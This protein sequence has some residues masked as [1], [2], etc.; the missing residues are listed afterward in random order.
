[1]ADRQSPGQGR[2]SPGQGRQSPG[3]GR[4]WWSHDSPIGRLT[5][6]VGPEGLEQLHLPGRSAPIDDA[7]EEPDRG[8]AAQLDEYFAG[9][10]REFT[11]PLDLSAV[12]SPY[13]RRVLHTLFRE[14]PWGE[15]VS[16]GELAEM[17][18]SPGTARAVGSTMAANPIAIVIPC[19]RVLAAGGRI[20]GYGGGLPVKRALLE[21]EGALAPALAGTTKL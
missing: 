2:Q 15:T 13:R 10:R 17:A 1:V 16:Y 21:L 8:V 3:Q 7:V 12:E 11:M 6:V 14:V 20:G 18:G 4:S 19:H 9:A 5:V